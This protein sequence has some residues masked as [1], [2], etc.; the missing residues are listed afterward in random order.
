MKTNPRF[1]Y[2]IGILIALCATAIAKSQRQDMQTSRR[3]LRNRKAFTND[4]GNLAFEL[5][6]SMNQDDV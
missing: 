6:S 5:E 3:F 4:W 1:Y 2:T